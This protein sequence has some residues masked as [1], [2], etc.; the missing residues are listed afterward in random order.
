MQFVWKFSVIFDISPRI[1]LNKVIQ[2]NQTLMLLFY[3]I[4]GYRMKN[5]LTMHINLLVTI[6]K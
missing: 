4:N 5:K 1:R 2:F 3:L 6:R